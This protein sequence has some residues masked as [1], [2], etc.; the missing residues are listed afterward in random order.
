MPL[1]KST[2]VSTK[3]LSKR[4]ELRDAT[5]EQRFRW[6]VHLQSCMRRGISSGITVRQFLDLTAQPCH[7]CGMPP[8]N[9][10]DRVRNER[11]YTKTNLVPCC[12]RCN[13]MKSQLAPEDFLAHVERISVF[14]KI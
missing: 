13:S 5:T 8:T 6:R 2:K 9:G 1:S 10:V 7:Y 14:Q 3:G 11:A 12:K 4:P